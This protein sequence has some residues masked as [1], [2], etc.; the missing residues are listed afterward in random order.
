MPA[1]RICRL[2]SETISGLISYTYDAVGNRKQTTSTV[3]GISSGTSTYDVN[4]RLSTD[5]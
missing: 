2:T 3:T 1:N 5:T 4:D